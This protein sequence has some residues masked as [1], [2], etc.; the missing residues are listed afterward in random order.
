MARIRGARLEEKFPEPEL[1]PIMNIIFMLILALV[2][3][4]ALLPL[5]VVSSETQKISKGLPGAPVEED[6]KKPLNL[7]LFITET[8]FNFQVYNDLKAGGADPRNPGRKLALIP[9][10]ET[11]NGPQYDFAALKAKFVEFKALDKAEETMTITA[12]PKVKFNTI[13]HAMDAARFDNDKKVLFPKVSFA[14]GIV[15]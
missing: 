13:I 9:M 5:G 10:V 6:K 2:S 11:P 4:A 12:D 1:L 15:G 3:M 14:A 8:G 7:V